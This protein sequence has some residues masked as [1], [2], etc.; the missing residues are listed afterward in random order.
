MLS[1]PIRPFGQSAYNCQ[2]SYL[3]FAISHCNGSFLV[4]QCFGRLNLRSFEPKATPRILV[5]SR[6]WSVAR[7]FLF[8]L[9]STGV[10]ARRRPSLWSYISFSSSARKRSVSLP[11]PNN[12]HGRD[13]Y[14]KSDSYANRSWTSSTTDTV[15]TSKEAWMTGGQRA[16]YIKTGGIIA[17][18]LFVLYLCIPN[19]S[20]GS[21][22]EFVKSE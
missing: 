19:Q 20:A 5:Y 3:S 21:V 6:V 22:K 11:K 10:E 7:P 12:N 8:S 16:R 13:S 18:V 15:E 4:A 14:K 2:Q 17:F 9:M 1:I